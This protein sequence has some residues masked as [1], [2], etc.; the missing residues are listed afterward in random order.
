MMVSDDVVERVNDGLVP[1]TAELI[2]ELKASGRRAEARDLLDAFRNS[3]KEEKVQIRREIKNQ[4]NKIR[5][6]FTVRICP[7]EGCFERVGAMRQRCVS[8]AKQVKNERRAEYDVFECKRY[9][10]RKSKGLCVRC[11]LASLKNHSL[12]KLH[13][14]RQNIISRNASKLRKNNGY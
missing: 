8:H 5:R 7:V 10:I 4:N 11:G 9:H 13:N 12:C 3:V 1:I 6:F 2:A 14:D